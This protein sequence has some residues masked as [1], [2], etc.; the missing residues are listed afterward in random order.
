MEARR[1]GTAPAV[2]LRP[3]SCSTLPRDGRIRQLQN[4]SLHEELA[5]LRQ[6]KS[7]WQC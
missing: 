2:A 7:G 6:S 1:E 3:G 5:T 4:S